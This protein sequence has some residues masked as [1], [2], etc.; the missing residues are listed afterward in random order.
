MNGWRRRLHFSETGLTWTAPS[1]AIP[2]PETAFAYAGTCLFEG[3]N[4]SEGRGTSSP[5]RLIG[6][7][8]LD[9]KILKS[10]DAQ[11][12][13]GFAL[14]PQKFTPKAS[15][16]RGEKCAGIA[17]TVM[18]KVMADPI[19]LAVEMLSKI[20]SRHPSELQWREEHFDAVAGTDELRH[21]IA[22]NRRTTGEILKSWKKN[23]NEFEMLRRN[24]LLYEG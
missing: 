8:W 3:T 4:I 24:Y 10:L 7:P 12:T 11:W 16:Y 2:S 9:P 20:K 22:D 14:S 23:L 17:I 13:A 15:K 21:D 18:D 6:A 5:F 19:A 1:P